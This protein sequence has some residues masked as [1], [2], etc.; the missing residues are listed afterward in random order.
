MFERL[1]ESLAERY[2]KYRLKSWYKKQQMYDFSNEPQKI[3]HALI[4]L[5][6]NPLPDNVL[7][8]LYKDLY[9]T[10]ASIKIST[11]ERSN[12][13]KQDCN[14]LNIPNNSYLGGYFAHERMDMVIDLNESQD[15]ISVYLTAMSNAPLRI[16]LN[17][18]PFDFVYN[19]YIDTSTK[20]KMADRVS[21]I[22]NY[23]KQ[24]HH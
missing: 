1:K 9:Q 22:S 3:N 20:D 10:F 11:F 24:L 17:R 2:I 4:I 8:Q 6:A 18:G 5:P 12:L 16:N 21:V 7:Q 23:L 13:R 19:L 14:W 15:I